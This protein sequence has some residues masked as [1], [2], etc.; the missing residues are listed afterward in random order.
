MTFCII[1]FCI[2]TFCDFIPIYRHF[3]FLCEC[4]SG[5]FLKS[6]RRG[7][8]PLAAV[9]NVCGILPYRLF[10]DYG[11]LSLRRG[12]FEHVKGLLDSFFSVG[13]FAGQRKGW[14]AKYMKYAVAA[15]NTV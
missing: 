12:L 8:F 4:Y 1:T 6:R 2:I 13:F 15:E 9:E 14:I 11:M 5:Q 7:G 3:L 10:F